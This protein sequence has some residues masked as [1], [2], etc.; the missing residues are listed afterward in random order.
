MVAVLVVLFLVV[1]VMSILLDNTKAARPVYYILGCIILVYAIVVDKSELPDYQVYTKY[2]T[3]NYLIIEP[4]FI[5]I[6]WIVNSYF[7]GG[8]FYLFAI[9]LL[10]GCGLKLKI[11]YKLSPLPIATLAVYLCSYFVYHELIQ[12]RA[13]LAAVFLLICIKYIKER[14]LKRF[15]I[16]CIAAILCHYS[17]IMIIPLWFISAEKK[18]S[19]LYMMLIPVGMV[20]NIQGIDLVKLLSYVPIPYIQD[21]IVS[22]SSVSLDQMDRGLLSA[23]EYN[24]FI[25]WYLL[26]VFIAYYFWII[27]DKIKKYSPYALLFLKIYTLGVSLLWLLASVPVA[28]TRTSEF[29]AVV[30]IPLIP[31]S[32]YSVKSKVLSYVPITIICMT[33]LYWIINSFIVS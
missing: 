19:L 22:Y 11:L 8:E 27:I 10:L 15:T 33:W 2:L 17:A 21:K 4:S 13:G 14:D 30:Q 20:L 6:R 23:D 24:P 26:K 31:L 5:F 32:I 25:T 7:G 18:H 12:I 29:L 1:L 16:C 9:Y 3:S 28:A